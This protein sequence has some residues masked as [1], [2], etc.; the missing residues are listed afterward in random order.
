MQ[1]GFL[2]VRLYCIRNIFDIDSPIWNTWIEYVCQMGEYMHTTTCSTNFFH[3]GLISVIVD[4]YEVFGMIQL[5]L[6]EL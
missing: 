4:H 6:N 3:I 2:Y 1:S 5:K